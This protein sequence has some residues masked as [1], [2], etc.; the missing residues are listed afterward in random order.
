MRERTTSWGRRGA[1][2][3]AVFSTLSIA[4][5]AS[6][7]PTSA[8][9]TAEATGPP[10]NVFVPSSYDGSVAIPLVVLLH[11]YTAS[12]DMAESYLLLQP[13]AEQRGFLYAHPDGTKDKMGQRFWNATDACCDMF[14]ARVD[15]SVRL[16]TFIEQVENTYNVDPKRIY[17]VGHSNGAFMSYRMACD[18][19]D[20]IAAIVS[21]A[22]ASFADPAKCKPSEPVNVLQIH[23]TADEIIDYR[24]G[25]I[26]GRTYPG[27]QESTTMWA[28]YNGCRPTPDASPAPLDLEAKI[29]GDE[30]AVS[31]Y[32]DCPAGG[33]VELWTVNGGAHVP[34]ISSTF[35]SRIIDFLFAHP[36]P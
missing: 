16:M 6:S 19:A 36:E 35:S 28:S 27:A 34:T 12:G 1:V 7:R 4:A 24:G 15:D 13:L 31:V 29:A 20:R 22:G 21:V 23:G 8:P 11:G 30:T 5:C 17:V 14:S 9:T 25:Q 26:E 10:A 2:V 33:A 18:H 3:L 32:T